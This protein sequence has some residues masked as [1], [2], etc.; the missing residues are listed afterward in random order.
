MPESETYE[1]FHEPPADWP[2]K[3]P[4]H[5]DIQLAYSRDGVNWSRPVDRSPIVPNGEPGSPD[6]GTTFVPSANPF[7]IDGDTY[8]YYTAVRYE[9]SERTQTAYMEAHDHDMRGAVS[10]MLAKMPEDHWVSLDAGT[11][12]GWAP[13]RPFVLPSQLL[14]N[15]DAEGGF[16][17]AEFLT[18]FGQ[19][20]E[21]LT[22]SACISVTANG[23]DQEIAWRSGVCPRDLADAH[24]GG[25]CLK[26]Y[27]KNA[28]LYSY[29]LVERDPDGAIGRYWDN[30]HWNEAIMHRSDNWGRASN[31]PAGGAPQPPG[32]QNPSGTRFGPN[33]R[34]EAKWS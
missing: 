18:P 2:S 27:L 14:V 7:V 30:A 33:P 20:V 10:C 8:I 22:R 34:A 32:T 17:E 15:A 1:V 24:R 21:G 4:G 16:V 13:A 19:P 3:K 6:A 23:K 12:E 5:V 25:L 26:L 9:H 11:H 28:K 31:E 29:T